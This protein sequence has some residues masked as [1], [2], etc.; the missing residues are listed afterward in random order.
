M[1][2]PSNP[3]HRYQV[4]QEMAVQRLDGQQ[5]VLPTGFAE[6]EHLK[7]GLQ[8]TMPLE[9]VQV[10]LMHEEIARLTNEGKLR[11]P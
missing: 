4:V 3:C 9:R 8:I 6:L 2:D 1:I 10:M 7:L 11:K 5:D